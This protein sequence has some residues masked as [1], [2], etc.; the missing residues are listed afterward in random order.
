MGV[1]VREKP[2]GSGVWWVFVRHQGKRTSK[3]VG[4]KRTAETVAEQ[5]RAKLALGTFKIN[6]GSKGTPTYN[7]YS[8]KWLEAVLTTRRKS[9]HERYD[10]ILKSRVWPTFGSEQIDTIRRSEI[11]DFLLKE[12]KKGT[13]R[14]TIRII[15]DVMNGPF[16]M[17]VEDEILPASPMTGITKALRLEAMQYKVRARERGSRSFCWIRPDPRTPES[18]H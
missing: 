3:R 16:K 15:R 11:R 10:Q 2:N 12:S 17:A 13:P 9:T 8:T 5:I 1:S 4:Q 6:D 14:A 7:E 18:I